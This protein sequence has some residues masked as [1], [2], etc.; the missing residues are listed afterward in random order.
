MQGSYLY[1][2]ANKCSLPSK[3]LW[4][5]SGAGEERPQIGLNLTAKLFNL[6]HFKSLKI[7]WESK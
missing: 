1:L 4:S 3:E 6:L 2:Q 5:W 7:D